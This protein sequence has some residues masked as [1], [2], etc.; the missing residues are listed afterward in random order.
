[1]DKHEH[2][3]FKL[4]APLYSGVGDIFVIVGAGTGEPPKD[5]YAEF[6]VLAA[7]ER[8][9]YCERAWIRSSSLPDTED[10]HLGRLIDEATSH[11]KLQLTDRLVRELN[12]DA[13]QPIDVRLE[14]SSWDGIGS[15]VLRNV[16]VWKALEDA[17]WLTKSETVASELRAI[18]RRYPE[19]L[20][21][22]VQKGS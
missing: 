1:M 21:F 17:S 5:R 18:R 20:N 7:G 11:A 22:T 16:V 2:R 15:S 3:V 9:P 12:L 14:P 19:L 13:R 4:A 8:P 6:I 10:G